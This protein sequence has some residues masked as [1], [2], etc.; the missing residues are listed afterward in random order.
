MVKLYAKAG[1]IDQKYLDDKYLIP[2]LGCFLNLSSCI[3]D[4]FLMNGSWVTHTYLEIPLFYNGVMDIALQEFNN[5]IKKRG[6]LA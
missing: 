3:Q 2:S 1:I 6:L 5:E 4:N